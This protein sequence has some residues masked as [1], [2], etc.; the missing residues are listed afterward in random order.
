M[1]Y[2]YSGGA[3]TA[4]GAGL[5]APSGSSLGT[6]PASGELWKG[7]QELTINMRRSMTLFETWRTDLFNARSMGAITMGTRMQKAYKATVWSF[8]RLGRKTQF[9]DPEKMDTIPDQLLT[10]Y[11]INTFKFGVR[12]GPDLIDVSGGDFKGVSFATQG[13]ERG[14][15]IADEFVAFRA[16]VAVSALIGAFG[17]AGLGSLTVTKAK[18]PGGTATPA[19]AD[20]KMKF[21]HLM[22]AQAVLGDMWDDIR[23]WI[24][25]S[26]P[27]HDMIRVNAANMNRFFNIGGLRMT[28]FMGTRIFVTDNPALTI[29]A[30]TSG[31]QRHVGQYRILGLRAGAM[32]LDRANEFRDFSTPVGG[33]SNLTYRL[34]EQ[35]ACILGVKHMKYTGA[36][37]GFANEFDV[38]ATLTKLQTAGNWS[39][40]IQGTTDIKDYFGVQLIV[41]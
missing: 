30:V 21:E 10:E 12:W 41:N 29:P 5:Y 28:D 8:N 9:R 7:L 32:F 15:Q 34:Q 17:A 37:S 36:G 23:I 2:P 13:N 25:P 26:K 35:D 14:M 6:P 18:M 31:G 16:R 38:G 22:E 11:D 3:Q 39:V 40:G 4:G 19:D 24:M 33:Q 20:S 27:W 1:P